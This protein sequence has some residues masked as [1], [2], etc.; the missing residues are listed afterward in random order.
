MWSL[1]AIIATLEAGMKQ[2]RNNMQTIILNMSM[3]HKQ[4]LPMTVD[5][6]LIFWQIPFWQD[7]Y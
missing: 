6:Y 3:T 5:M 4:M 7:F 2:V 1:E